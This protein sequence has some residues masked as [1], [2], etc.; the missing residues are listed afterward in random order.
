MVIGEVANRYARA[1]F[2]AASEINK[3]K[4]VLEEIRIFSKLL[5]SDSEVKKFLNSP[6]VPSDIKENCLL[7]SLK[8]GGLLKEVESFILLLARKGRLNVFSEI[9]E[10]YQSLTDEANQVVRGHVTSAVILKPEDRK[11]IE[12]KVSNYL[13]KKVILNFNVDSQLLGGLVAQVGCF[14]FD[15]TLVC[16]MKRM[17]EELKRRIN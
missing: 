14:T 5:S 11:A 15:D 7:V 6:L 1:L 2:D 12:D 17:R 3:T 8:N 10:S 4:N 13:K 9:V 16:H